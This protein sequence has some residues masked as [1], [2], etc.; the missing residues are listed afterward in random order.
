[1]RLAV[2]RILG[3]LIATTLPVVPAGAQE[4]IDIGTLPGYSVGR[5]RGI[6]LRGDVVG[7][8]ARVGVEP[9]EQAVLWRRRAHGRF[10]IESLP[11]LPGFTRTD[12]RD[13]AGG[14]EPVGFSYVLA[15]GSAHY[16]AVLWRR[17]RSGGRVPVDLEPPPG[18]TDARAYAASRPGQIVG[19]AFNPGEVVN[20]STLRHAVS[21]RFGREGIDTCDLGVPEGFDSSA[22][23]D[24]NDAGDV[25]GTA[26]RVESNGAG[27]LRQRAEVV[28]WPRPHGRTGRCDPH[29]FLLLDRD[30]LP[31]KQTPSIDEHGNVVVRADLIAP[32]Q[33]TISRALGWARHGWWYRHAFELPVPEGFTDAYP[34]DVNRHGVV[35]TALV[36][37]ADGLTTASQG[38][39]WKFARG[40]WRSTLLPN[41]AGVA[42]ASVGQISDTGEIVGLAP[43]PA[44]GTSG[45]LLWRPLGHCERYERDDDEDWRAGD[46]RDELVRDS[47]SYPRGEAES[48]SR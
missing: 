48:R 29:P 6:N 3:I 5:A 44:A 37:G 46:S 12:A 7:Q 20:G 23:F 10:A 28:V 14:H 18:F 27:G 24:V 8:A 2:G 33:P 19:E 41:P 21:W 47:R 34:S 17:D 40:H 39:S 11:P 9:A 4:P 30:D 32:G 15:P 35:G 43:A 16:R 42:V 1:M 13:F 25:V 31:L 45:A 36:R 38:V 22:A 26:S